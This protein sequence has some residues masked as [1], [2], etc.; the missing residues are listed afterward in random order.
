MTDEDNNAI[1]EQIIVPSLRIYEGDWTGQQLPDFDAVTI[2][3]DGGLDSDLDWQNQ[4]KLAEKATKAGYWILWN[5]ELG[6][7]EHL[8]HSLE[9]QSQFLSLSLAVE[10]FR[11]TLWKEFKDK[12]AGLSIYRGRAN[13]SEQ[14]RWDPIHTEQLNE[15]L[16]EAGISHQELHP[17]H[18]IL[19]CRDVCVQYM[20]LLVS[21]IPDSLPIYL[22]LDI[23]PF[24][25]SVLAQLLV[26][27]PEKFERF[28]LALC[29]HTLPFPSLGWGRA[30]PI[31]YAGVDNTTLPFPVE[32]AAIAICIPPSRCYLPSHYACLEEAVKQLQ[33][34]ELPFRLIA[35]SE[36]ISQWHGLDYLIY[37]PDSLDVTG[38]RKLQGF[39]AAGGTAVSS[40]G[41]LIGLAHEI[42]LSA[43]ITIVNK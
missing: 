2:T 10:H 11:D 27:N 1:E 14:L 18:K 17:L 21:R 26:L 16:K 30:S 25:K 20:T 12:T 31:G 32:P 4:R 38:K 22:F 6:L 3:L 33:A 39:C 7:F 36:L 34:L 23:S 24:A 43:F 13:F 42:T 40:T 29:S 9:I 15:W 35:E 8:V 37:C 19:F 5:I 28:S 41:Q